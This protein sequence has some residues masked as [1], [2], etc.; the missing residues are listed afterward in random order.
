MQR[1]WKQIVRKLCDAQ[2][3]MRQAKSN[4]DEKKE[5]KDSKNLQ[6]AFLANKEAIRGY[7]KSCDAA[8]YHLQEAKDNEASHFQEL[9]FHLKVLA[10]ALRQQ[11]D[12][13]AADNYVALSNECGTFASGKMTKAFTPFPGLK[14]TATREQK[15]QQADKGSTKAVLQVTGTG[16]GAKTVFVVSRG[17]DPL[18]RSPDSKTQPAAGKSNREPA[19]SLNNT[20]PTGESRVYSFLDPRFLQALVTPRAPATP[21]RPKSATFGRSNSSTSS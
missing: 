18:F 21:E 3:M 4:Y 15:T 12:Y 8:L 11:E 16:N 5:F 10:N 9:E 7:K 14:I 17:D 20:S 19:V 13:E 1:N 2:E 6:N